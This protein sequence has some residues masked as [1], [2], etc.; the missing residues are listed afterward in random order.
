[1]LIT[2]IAAYVRAL[3]ESFPLM[4]GLG[5]ILG[6]VTGGVPAYPRE[7]STVALILA[8]TFSLTEVRFSGISLR[9]EARAFG[10]AAGWNYLALTGLI[11][12]LSIM[13]S[14]PSIRS[15]WVVMAA[16]PSAIAV[17]PL[18]A[19][20]GGNVRSSLVSTAFLYLGALAI[21]PAVTVAFAG[22]A[23]NLGDLA[24]QILVQIALPMVVSRPLASN[25]AVARHRSILV[26]LSFFTLVFTLVGANRNVFAQD[27]VLI[28]ALAAGGLVRTWGLGGVA[29]ILSPRL[30]ADSAQR[31]SDT[32]FA[33]LKNLGLAALL[34]FS[35]FGARAALPAIVSLFCE[36]SWLLPMSRL[37][38]R[39]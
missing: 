12:A 34:A 4:V 5:A 33:S 2:L 17:I 22:Q 35:L 10:R 18:T 24:V 23:V 15:G 39:L 27:S 21:Y 36:I 38:R 29:Y 8:M 3:W 30:G 9:A 19:A 32:L 6:V 31:V 1:M 7:V 28:A 13:Y 20:F 14:D 26:N 37:F 16:L 25:A 11:L